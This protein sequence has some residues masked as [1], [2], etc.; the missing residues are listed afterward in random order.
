MQTTIN[1]P[2]S[3][4]GSVRKKKGLQFIQNNGSVILIYG[5]VLVIGIIAAIYSENF[6]TPGNMINLL[7]QSIV[8]GFLA[9]AQSLVV[10]TGGMDMSS[11][12]VARTVGLTIATLF[13]ANQSNPALIFPLLLLGLAIGAVIG[14]INGLLVTGTHANPFI[15]T[16]GMASVLRGID[17]AISSVPIRGVPEQYTAIYT[18]KIGILPLCVIGMAIIWFLM[19]LFTTRSRLGRNIYAVGGSERVSLLSGIRINRTLLTTYVMASTFAAAAGLFLLAR[20]GVGDPSAAEGLTFQSVCA[21]AVGGISLYGGRGSMIG[22]LGGVILLTLLGNV[23]NML[24]VNIYYQ[25]LLLGLI[26]LVAV[27]AYKVRSNQ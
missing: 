14:L 18:A 3:R 26:V 19:Y 23:F 16:F 17:L 25:Q 22:T 8:L 15:L 7:R 10:L 1:Q 9:I 12:M 20:M 27:A 5:F 4:A 13:A 21:V 2:I 6:R 24:Q 11:D